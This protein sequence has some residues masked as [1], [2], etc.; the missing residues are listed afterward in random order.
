MDSGALNASL[1]N[2]TV[3]SPGTVNPRDIH[4]NGNT[5]R[6]GMG[7]VPGTTS[8]SASVMPSASC[9]NPQSS[10]GEGLPSTSY[11]Q[12]FNELP[13]HP[14]PPPTIADVPMDFVG[15]ART[16]ISTEPVSD[17][18]PKGTWRVMEKVGI[19]LHVHENGRCHDPVGHACLAAGMDDPEFMKA[20]AKLGDHFKASVEETLNRVR[21]QRDD[22]LDERDKAMDERDRA[23]DERDEQK[24]SY[25]N[26]YQHYEKLGAELKELKAQ[27]AQQA[28][29]PPRRKPNVK[30]PNPASSITPSKSSTD[31]APSSAASKRKKP[32]NSEDDKMDVDSDTP[33]AKRTNTGNVPE[34]G[35]D[36][37]IIKGRLEP[38]VE[39]TL[40][41]HA[42][43]RPGYE[44][45]RTTV[46]W[47]HETGSMIIS[48]G[49]ESC[50]RYHSMPP[51]STFIGVP[52]GAQ[53]FPGSVEEANHLYTQA[54]VPGNWGAVQ[55]LQDMC[56]LARIMEFLHS[57]HPTACPAPNSVAKAILTFDMNVDWT[58]H[59]IFA[60]PDQCYNPE[61]DTL[62][63]FA[64][65][66]VEI[67]SCLAYP[68]QS[69]SDIEWAQG[70][71][72]HYAHSYHYGV[73][74]SDSGH[75]DLTSVRAFRLYIA[76]TPNVDHADKDTLSQF[77][78]CFIALTAYIG[79][80]G[81]IVSHD[82]L[83]ISPIRNITSCPKEDLTNLRTLAAHFAKCGVTVAEVESYY[84]F[85][86][87]YCLDFCRL[88]YLPRSQRKHYAQIFIMAQ[89]RAFFYPLPFPPNNT[90]TVPSHWK[91]DQIKEYRRR[92]AIV[93]RW[94]D[95][96]LNSIP[97]SYELLKIHY[98]P[99]PDPTP[100]TQVA[101][102]SITAPVGGSSSQS[103]PGSSQD[104][105]I[106]A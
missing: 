6:F 90:Y 86:M 24:N 54:K 71:F 73:Y 59:T 41:E 38:H 52:R 27:Q 33:P 45:S 34:I 44:F 75:I 30:A 103:T 95:K 53:I 18:I 100:S 97:S 37:A 99:H 51:T 42:N 69:A 28:Q 70:I 101:N 84:R 2:H 14:A 11:A 19:I 96:R 74:L 81:V 85:G 25:R 49:I 15:G 105:D 5:A 29:K 55:Q 3:T 88:E 36:V 8:S 104:P 35:Y 20:Y 56:S 77:K 93:R 60:D 26:L 89:C 43:F 79:L 23:V 7:H 17:G 68:P 72:T 65:E 80:Y 67:P 12:G 61:I 1:G 31:S 58:A 102:M 62:V 106:K 98:N 16:A 57:L 13:F 87:K 22:A 63:K 82:H 94:R 10:G 4:G 66:G 40:V 64:N 50:L 92:S 39:L 21:R 91:L 9:P 76:M 48:K 47:C 32:E 78:R 83:N 46:K